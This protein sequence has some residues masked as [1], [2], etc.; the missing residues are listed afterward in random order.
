MFVIP[1]KGNKFETFFACRACPIGDKQL[2]LTYFRKSNFPF[3]VSFNITLVP[4]VIFYTLHF[5]RLFF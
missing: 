5:F 4:F 3:F 1:R 2:T